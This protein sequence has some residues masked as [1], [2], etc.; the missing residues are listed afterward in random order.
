[1]LNCLILFDLDNTLI[2]TYISDKIDEKADVS[3]PITYK[4]NNQTEIVEW[5]EYINIF[6]RP[7]VDKLLKYV[8]ENFTGIGIYTYSSEIYAKSIIDKIWPHIK[9]NFI[10][11]REDCKTIKYP[12]GGYVDILK[13]L[14]NI[15]NTPESIYKDWNK[16]N[17]L[18]FDDKTEVGMLNPRNLF[19]VKYFDYKINLHN[20]I[21]LYELITLLQLLIHNKPK[22]I[23]L[24]IENMIINS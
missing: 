20:D 12:Y 18:L 1:M 2:S 17:T 23:R 5:V 3:I 22:D 13:P 4:T 11:T 6:K 8:S 10:K 7:A 24:F 14:I 9:F 16:K 15:W 21:Y 19:Q